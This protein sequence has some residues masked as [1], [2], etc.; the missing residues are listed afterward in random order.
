MSEQLIID[1]ASL[2]DEEFY[3]AMFT[4]GDLSLLMHEG[5]LR[6][7]NAVHAWRVLDPPEGSG[8][9]AG[10]MPRVFCI[11][12]SGRFGGTTGVMWILYEMGIWFANLYNRPMQLRFTSAWQ[13]SIDEIIGAVTPQCFEL[14]PE[15]CKPTYH[16]KRGP[17]PAGLYFPEYGP[18]LGLRIAL[19]GLD[20]NPDAT[21]GQA[22][23]GDVVSE[24]AFVDK[25]DYTLRSVLYRQYQGR[26]WA[27]AII[28]SSAPRDLD[29]DWERTFVP[30]CKSRNAYFSATIEDNNLLSR[31]KKD[32]FIAAMGGRGDPN[33]EREYF[34]VISGD[35]QL[36]I[37]PEFDE[38]K[39]VRELARPTHAYAL[40][41]AD[42]GMTHLFGLV[43]GYY[44]FDSSRLVVQASDALNNTSTMRVAAITAAREFDLWGTWPP[45]KMRHI[46]L[47]T[48][49]DQL[50]W[51][52]LLLR[53]PLAHLGKD[54][55]EM[56]QCDV[57]ER[58]D[59]ERAP[60]A[61][62][63]QDIPGAF[64]YFD[65]VRHQPNPYGRKSDIDRAMVRDVEEM[66]GLE[67]LAT[68]KDELRTVMVALVRN[69]IA[70]GRLMFLPGAGPVIDHVRAGKWHKSRSKFAE[71]PV[72]GHFDCIAAGE[73][74]ETR[75]GPKPIS[76]I[77]EGDRVWTR[78]GLK[79][80][81][82]A[83]SVGDRPTW[84]LTTDCG[85]VTGT[86]DHRVWTEK[87]WKPLSEI[88]KKDT[89]FS[90]KYR[91][92]TQVLKV[93]ATGRTEKVYDLTVEDEHEFFVNGILVHN[94]LAATVYLCRE[95]E[96]IQ[97]ER[98]FPPKAVQFAP[99]LDVME[100]VPWA[101]KEPW[102]IEIEE[103]H[104]QMR[105]GN[106]GRMRGT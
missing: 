15:S 16:G 93:E 74:V 77:L 18:T 64:S 79:T 70:S 52:D 100:R 54:L 69:W 84:K 20:V 75:N 38:A 25:L 86:A 45:N 5:Q 11:A 49:G 81:L 101:D 63:R 55:C 82:R 43:Y 44:D 40:T 34:N 76:S 50:G 10:S 78:A 59:Y 67:F 61:F 14:A 68:S 56:A 98:P 73:L 51:N 37:I 72:F 103:A 2:T 23:D 46:P 94:C 39:H 88:T 27:R 106:S 58:P 91:G 96:L 33:C 71:H 104:K 65:G 62:I 29:T 48:Q 87:G 24:A 42:P 97:N 105:G 32:E 92:G 36:S 4:N 41:A 85:T 66:F 35:P 53:H 60:G 21:R 57:R 47:E 8:L 30:D 17:K 31:A 1:P 90:L 13:K 83:W 7:R 19:A 3:E 80:V 22:S 28:E 6:M 9:Q 12:K 26:P 99:G 89:V 95:A 102:E